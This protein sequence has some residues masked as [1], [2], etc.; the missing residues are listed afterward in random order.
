MVLSSIAG[1]GLLT[2]SACGSASVVATD[3]GPNP[4]VSDHVDSELRAKSFLYEIDEVLSGVDGYAGYGLDDDGLL[5]V[6]ARPD[7]WDRATA[8]SVSEIVARAEANGT[9]IDFVDVLYGESELD[10]ALAIFGDELT[11]R[12]GYEVSW[13][14]LAAT[15]DVVGIAGPALSE[16]SVAQER[17]TQLLAEIVDDAPVLEFLEFD[18]D[19][20]AQ[21]PRGV[22]TSR[23]TPTG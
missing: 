20:S 23:P 4:S 13:L 19:S 8:S 12:W 22:V 5:K 18:P 9:T 6:W 14:G 17:A 16:D 3:S 21:F 1:I 11:S 7:D 15:S 10:D 2:L